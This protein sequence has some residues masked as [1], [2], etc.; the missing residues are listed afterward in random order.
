M[1]ATQFQHIAQFYNHRVQQYGHDPRSCDYGR[2]ESQLKK[3]HVLSEALDYSGKSV[4]DVGCGLADYAGYLSERYREISYSGVDL[5]HE[6]I[7]RAKLAFPSL[8]L[9]VT[10][11]LEEPSDESH[12]VVSANG[13]FY[14]LGSEAPDLMKKLIEAMFR[15]CRQC[16]A[17]NSLSTWA[18]IHEKGEFYA[19]PA[20]VLDWC[21]ELTPW[22]TLRHD[23]LAHDF[24]VYLYKNNPRQ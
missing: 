21:R 23:Y 22:V 17:F 20:L 18:S 11:I 15:R 13:I 3:F 7:A 2:K 10:N 8:E 4:L 14:L 1:N 24:T 5:S 9:R 12:D 6:M 16:T 19:D